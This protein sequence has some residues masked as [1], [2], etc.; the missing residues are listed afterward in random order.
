MCLYVFCEGNSFAYEKLKQPAKALGAAFQK[1]NFLRD[2]K[3]DFVDLSRIYFPVA[4]F[5]N[6]T[7]RDKD[8][9]EEDIEADFREAYKGVLE[10][11]IKARFG[12][13]V[14]YK[15]YYRCLKR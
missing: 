9:I 4:I 2:I 11:P 3:A 5:H 1:V 13:Y 6:F 10:L 12:V 7:E 8:Q 15:Y 14:A